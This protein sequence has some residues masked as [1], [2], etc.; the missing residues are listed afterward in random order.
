MP[1]RLSPRVQSFALLGLALIALRT[2][3]QTNEEFITE[4]QAQ[5]AVSWHGAD[6]AHDP[7]NVRIIGINDFHGEL[8][9]RA[10]EINGKTRL[11]GGAAVLAGYVEAAGYV[12][13]TGILDPDQAAH[14]ATLVLIAGDTV[15]A[16]PP[17]SGLLRDEPT[18]AIFNEF[19]GKECPRLTPAWS[20]QPSPVVTHCRVLAVPGN[21]E[22][23]K[24]TAEFERLLYGGKH[25]GGTVL[26]H[27]WEGMRIPYLAANI[28]RRA[29]GRPLLPSSAI[30]EMDRVRIGIIGAITAETPGLVVAGRIAD[31][32]ISAE[33]AAIN[34][35]VKKLNALGVKTIVLVI[36]EGLRSPV[37]PQ[38]VAPLALEEVSGRLAEVLGALDGGIDVV[39]A[40]HTHKF[41]NVMV[42]LKDGKLALVT[43]AIGTS[44]ALSIIDLTI[45]RPAGT[46]IAKS[47]RIATTWADG[48][49][50]LS[51]SKKVA[52]IV[53]AAN[54][55]T[56]PIVARSIGVAASA[57]VR[58]ETP[59]GE[60]PLGNFVAEAQRAAAGSDFAF[61]NA[62]G[63]RSDLPAGPITFGAIYAVEPFGNIVT[64]VSLTGAEVVELLEEQWSGS[65]AASPRYLRSAGLR[66]VFDLRRAPGHRVIA[67]WDAANQPLDRAR[68][69]TVA[70]ND[71]LLGGGDFYPV[72]SQATDK[73][74]VMTDIAALEAFIK[75]SP[76]PVSGVLDGR[77]ERVDTPI[78]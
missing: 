20:S 18:L 32:S 35:E 47:A 63:L 71:F 4:L 9:P 66:Y 14:S 75:K 64:R 50:G 39:V 29:D 8:V 54:K 67:A 53:A 36:H 69:Y 41:N 45:D 70:V 12:K 10:L 40:G 17:I 59:S 27:D 74:E 28:T 30:I 55:A 16:S 3:A 34:A 42:P 21:H 33:A 57:L 24:G 77:L 23:D 62:G 6:L 5:A 11:L 76:G 46:V 52:K 15:G 56:A 13:D 51:P 61:V 73:T 25:P 31:L 1:S 60:S 19:A 2:P 49:A 48:G 65:H 43:Q 26:G 44:S 72:L 58:A 37:T 38:W 68:R 78:N 22:F 7:L